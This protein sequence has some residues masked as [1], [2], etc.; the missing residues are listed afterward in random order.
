MLWRK[1]TTGDG[2]RR[3][4]RTINGYLYTVTVRDSPPG[5]GVEWEA[6]VERKRPSMPGIKFNTRGNTANDSLALED[7]EL[8]LTHMV[9]TAAEF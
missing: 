3:Y 6:N 5:N 8:L 9:A 1:E 4:A 2:E 7:A